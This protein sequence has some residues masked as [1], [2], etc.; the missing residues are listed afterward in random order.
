MYVCLFSQLKDFFLD[1]SASINPDDSV[2]EMSKFL[3]RYDLEHAYPDL[4]LIGITS[5]NDLIEIKRSMISQDIGIRDVVLKLVQ[6]LE[7]EC[8]DQESDIILSKPVGFHS[9]R[10]DHYDKSKMTAA[11][12]MSGFC[13][14]K[15]HPIFF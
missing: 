11:T 14:T 1:L 9:P 7:S 2:T 3:K 5:I 13:V 15:S 4:I 12:G 6:D 8:K 10:H